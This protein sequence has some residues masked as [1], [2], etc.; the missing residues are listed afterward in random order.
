MKTSPTA[1]TDLGLRSR[2]ISLK[3]NKLATFSEINQEWHCLKTVFI[4]SDE[5]NFNFMLY[6]KP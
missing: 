4:R 6:S 5:L 3:I 1:Q 2:I